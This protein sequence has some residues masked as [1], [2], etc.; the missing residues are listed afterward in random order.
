MNLI[1]FEIFI[2]YN[3]IKNN[4]FSIEVIMNKCNVGF[5]GERVD[6]LSGTELLGN[7]YRAFSPK[8]M[9]FGT[10]DSWSPFGEGGINP[11]LFCNNDPINQADPTGHMSWTSMTGIIMGSLSI[12]LGTVS[13][14]TAIPSGGASIAAAASVFTALSGLAADGAAIYSSATSESQPQ[15]SAIVGWAAIGLGIVSLGAGFSALGLMR[16]KSPMRLELVNGHY[17]IAMSGRLKGWF[18]HLFTR[19]VAGAAPIER[20]TAHYTVT[21]NIAKYLSGND[22]AAL[23][24]TSRTMHQ[25]VVQNTFT[26]SEGAEN[27][28]NLTGSY[29]Y[30]GVTTISPG[31]INTLRAAKTMIGE[32]QGALPQSVLSSPHRHTLFGESN[33]TFSQRISAAESRIRSANP[34]ARLDP[35]LPPHPDAPG[36]YMTSSVAEHVQVRRELRR[37]ANDLTTPLNLPF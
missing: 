28:S 16:F 4:Y 29:Y 33:Y 21:Q 30:Q 19:P 26:L 6:L 11:Y 23:A 5:N 25:N 36:G 17:G 27:I 35:T 32:Q 7:G 22:L 1:D 31:D 8:L 15:T 37:M 34:D 2:I 12:I 14:I 20:A 9:R 3:V 13:L 10:P 24:A 18:S